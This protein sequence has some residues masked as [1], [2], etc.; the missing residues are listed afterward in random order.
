M[1]Y[2]K[3]IINRLYN[4]FTLQ[5]WNVGFIPETI[6]EILEGKPI[7]MNI[8]K[9]N[10]KDRW[11]A[12]PFILDVTDDIV[13]LLV[14]ELYNKW[15]KGRIS[16]LTIDRK[17]NCILLV[18]PILQIESHLS[19]PAIQRVG[20]NKIY[21]YPENAKGE[22]LP[23]Y[24]YCHRSNNIE[25]VR[26]IST[27][28]LADAII[29]NVLGEETMF[30]TEIPSHNGNCL[31]QYRILDS[32]VEKIAQYVFPGNIARNAG[33]W[34]KYDGKIYRPAQ[35]CNKQYGG[36]VVL[37]EV[38][39]VNG[40]LRF[41]DIRRIKSSNCRYTTGCHT[42]NHYKGVTVVDVHGYVY[43]ILGWLFKTF[44]PKCLLK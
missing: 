30:A 18:E 16:K 23:M 2:L 7:T 39:N 25:L 26:V 14:E 41:N 29:T 11:F 10:Y 8:C 17:A 28:P 37:Q 3:D 12:D 42:F 43:P 24:E 44:T 20:G 35:D 9:H 40:S 27:R 22:G 33:D 34:L 21:I 1:V 15:G 32:D 38:E 31:N 13:Y 36:A 4:R 5:R 19:F 6:D